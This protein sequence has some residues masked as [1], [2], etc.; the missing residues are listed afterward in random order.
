M[1]TKKETNVSLTSVGGVAVVYCSN[2]FSANAIEVDTIYWHGV[3][4][5]STFCVDVDLAVPQ[6]LNRPLL[7][8]AVEHIRIEWK[9]ALRGTTVATFPHQ[10]FNHRT[11]VTLLL[12]MTLISTLPTI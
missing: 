12:A 11:G 6:G 4:S 3:I 10:S 7:K 8:S 2:T 1:Y 5:R 9:Y